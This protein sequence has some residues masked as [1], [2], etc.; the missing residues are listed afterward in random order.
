MILIVMIFATLMASPTA[1]SQSCHQYETV[2]VELGGCLYTTGI[3]ITPQLNAVSGHFLPILPLLALTAG[4]L[5]MGRQWQQIYLP[6]N[7]LIKPTTPP[8][9][10]S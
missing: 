7:V 10:F 4:F 9:R 3:S 2:E 5:F 1:V 6:G 8:P